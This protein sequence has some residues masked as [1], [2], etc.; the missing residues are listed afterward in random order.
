[1]KTPHEL[2]RH[3]ALIAVVLTFPLLMPD[4]RAQSPTP[5][6]C[7]TPPA[8][9]QAT[10]WAQGATVNVLIDPTFTTAQQ[11]PIKDQLENESCWVHHLFSLTH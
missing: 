11:Q 8:Q 3:L 6:P 10:T 9:G 2:L 5:T 4:A 7:A 1:M